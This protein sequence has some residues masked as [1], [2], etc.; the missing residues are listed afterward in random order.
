[1]LQNAV[2]TPP[3]G[4]A[5]HA[6]R[7]IIP[8]RLPHSVKP[9]PEFCSGN[10]RVVLFV[11]LPFY[12]TVVLAG[13]GKTRRGHKKHTSGAK[14]RTHFQRANGT[15]KLVP[16]PQ[17]A[18]TRVFPQAV[19]SCPAQTRFDQ[20]F[21]QPAREK[22]RD[23]FTWLWQRLRRWNPLLPQSKLRWPGRVGRQLLSA[24]D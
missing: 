8:G 6:W 14:A 2:Q 15:S 13:C 7:G 20:S 18:R 17:P 4:L 3:S 5:R 23:R 24:S 19:N 21:P 1:R 9:S 16:F 12:N 22:T 10:S 11:E